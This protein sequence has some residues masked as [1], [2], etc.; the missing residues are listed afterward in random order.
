MQ[1]TKKKISGLQLGLARMN[2][3]QWFL[4]AIAERFLPLNGGRMTSRE[5]VRRAIEF[6]HPDRIP[7][8]YY[9]IIIIINTTPKNWQPPDGFYP[10]V[11]PHD[12]HFGGWRWKKR[13]DS[14]WLREDRTAIDEF[15]VVWR[16]N[17]TASMGEPIEGPLSGGWH[18]LKDYRLPD[19]RDED[20][21]RAFKRLLRLVNPDRYILGC[22]NTGLGPWELFR[23]LRGFENAMIDLIECPEE[24]H[25]LLSMITD[26][27][28]GS[29]EAFAEAGADGYYF[30]DD[31]G[32]QLNSFISPRHFSEYFMPCYR[33]ITGRCHDLGMHCGIHSC[34]NIR[35]LVPLLIEAGFD[36]LQLDSPDL[37]GIDWLS[38]NAAGRICLFCSEDIQNVYVTNDHVKIEEYV[39]TMIRRLSSEKGGLVLWPYSQP[40]DIG[41]GASTIRAEQRIYKKYRNLR[42]LFKAT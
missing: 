10:Y 30:L 18:L 21:L 35:P 1:R 25:R 3:T 5:R 29:L 42:K 14:R 38:E 7:H 23:H 32:T 19:M 2:E 22:D 34:G 28:L 37:C 6:A 9:D 16:A 36:F 40:Y 17:A 11:Q 8:R 4:R 27:F 12:V 39:K 13:K 26:M 20:R 24:V 15:G 31:W 33:K 41:V